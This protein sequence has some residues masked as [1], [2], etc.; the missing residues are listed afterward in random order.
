MANWLILKGTD[1]RLLATEQ[2]IMTQASPLQSLDS[3]VLS[4]EN[5]ARGYVAGGGNPMEPEPSIP[6]ECVDDVIAIARA[7]YLAQDPTGTLLTPIRQKER[8]NAY[9]HLKDIAKE[10]SAITPAD[11]SLTGT[12]QEL[13]YGKWGSKTYF[14]MRTDPIPGPPPPP[15]VQLDWS[16]QSTIVSLI[17]PAQP[18]LNTV[19]TTTRSVLSLME[20]VIGNQAQSFQL[21][22]GTADPVDPGQ[23]APLD[24]DLAMNNK[25][26]A[27]VA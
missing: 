17:G 20:V 23:V 18:A 24:Y 2:T 15:P 13:K 7:T 3:C 11:P 8:D 6:T 5:V 9:L 1:V 16:Y 19:P 4:A 21:R 14:P 26:W 12:A 27:K 22:A 10:I 25:Y